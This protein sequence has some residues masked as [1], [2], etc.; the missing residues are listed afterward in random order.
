MST[1]NSA[2]D[3]IPWL[4]LL[5]DA[6]YVKVPDCSVPV[7]VSLFDGLNSKTSASGCASQRLPGMVFLLQAHSCKFRTASVGVLGA[8]IDAFR[9]VSLYEGTAMCVRFG[10]LEPWG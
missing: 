10:A 4:F 7:K 8:H 5:L 1:D 9:W 6:V 2:D 3:A